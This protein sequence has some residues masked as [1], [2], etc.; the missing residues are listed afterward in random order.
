MIELLVVITIIGILASIVLAS[1]GASRKKGRDARRLT[2]MKQVQVA[3]ELYFDA[4]T[5]KSYPASALWS[6]LSVLTT[7]GFMSVLPQDVLGGSYAYEYQSTNGATSPA[8]CN[9][10]PCLGFLLRTA[11]EVTNFMTADITGI[12][13]IPSTDC[14]VAGGPPYDY[15]VKI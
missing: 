12:G 13:V 4:G 7:S 9:T 3:L 14:T 15:C 1:L 10:A 8:I 5:P 2:D 11:T 6:G